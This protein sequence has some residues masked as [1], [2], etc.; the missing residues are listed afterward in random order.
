MAASEFDNDLKPGS[1]V[2]V[3]VC[4]TCKTAQAAEVHGP[5][6]IDALR[7]ALADD[8]VTVRP[9][10][11]LGVCKRPTTVAVSGAQGFTFVFGDLTPVAAGDIASFVQ[12]YRAADYGF[13]PWR[14]RPEILRRSLVA[15]LPPAAWSPE[16]GSSP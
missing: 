12:S 10:Q 15:R 8:R 9:V 6:L 2:I 14:E 13:V 5:V 3:S 7:A 11:C 4:V 16:D 1:P